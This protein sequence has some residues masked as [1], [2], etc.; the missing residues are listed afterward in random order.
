MLDIIRFN[1]F[2][3]NPPINISSNVF[4]PVLKIL[5]FVLASSYNLLGSPKKSK[6]MLVSNVNVS[7][8]DNASANE[9]SEGET[10]AAGNHQ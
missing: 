5:S 10:A 6:P 9:H 7:A 3:C 8:S 2:S 4:T 1:E